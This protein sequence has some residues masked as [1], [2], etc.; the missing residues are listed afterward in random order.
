MISYYSYVEIERML[1]KVKAKQKPLHFSYLVIVTNVSPFPLCVKV[2][3]TAIATDNKQ[4]N[5]LGYWDVV[6]TVRRYY[7][8]K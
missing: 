1:K 6:V 3:L 8:S 4:Y 2:I 5:M 7:T